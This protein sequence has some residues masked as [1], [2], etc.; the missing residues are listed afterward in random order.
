MNTKTKQ[1]AA[2]LGSLP[3]LDDAQIQK[4]HSTSWW[5]RLPLGKDTSG[6]LIITPGRS[7]HGDYRRDYC[8]SIF[9][10]PL[11]LAGL[12]VL[13]IGAWDG[14]FSFECERRGASRVV[15]LDTSVLEDVDN[16]QGAAQGTGPGWQGPPGFQFA[17]RVLDSRVEF[18]EGNI[19]TLSPEVHGTFDLV[20]CYGVVYH[21]KSPLIG[22]ERVLSVTRDVAL[23]E[24]ERYS[25]PSAT[26]WE[27]LQHLPLWAYLPGY[28]DDS[29]FWLPTREGLSSALRRSGFAEVETVSHPGYRVTMRAMREPG[30]RAKIYGKETP[31]VS[32][33]PT[34]SKLVRVLRRL[35]GRVLGRVG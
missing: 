33:G 34:H 30:S 16:H 11:D 19:Y 26:D 4:M 1:Y 22:I 25:D 7:P 15:A 3:T 6:R 21:L 24:S 8:T 13:D 28:G 35:G 27:R 32:S 2:L 5:H 9:G 23:F 12:S 31:R 17:K 14:L 18:Q 10:L 29:T 20:L